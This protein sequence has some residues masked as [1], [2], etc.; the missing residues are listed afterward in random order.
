MRR[1]LMNSWNSIAENDREFSPTAADIYSTD[2]RRNDG[3]AVNTGLLRR[4]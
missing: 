1:D 4:R 2:R 3:N